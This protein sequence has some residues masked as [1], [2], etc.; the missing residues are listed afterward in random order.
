MNMQKM[1]KQAQQMQAE[2]QKKQGE[3]ELKT[4]SGTAGG[5]VV[6]IQMKGNYE[7]IGIEINDEL[8]DVEEKEILSEMIIMAT[9]N[10]INKIN[11]ELNSEL[12]SMTKGLP[13]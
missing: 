9:N 10:A 7:M 6:K 4:F 2:M 5:E 1:M 11:E 8:L 12:G 13:F 3:I